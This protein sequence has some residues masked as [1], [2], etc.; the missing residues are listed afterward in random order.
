M[1]PEVDKAPVWKLT[2]VDD[3]GTR[4]VLPLARGE[5]NVGRDADNT[6]RL[7]ERNVSRR[8]M[9]LR[10]SD[11]N[12]WVVEDLNSY[13]GCY[14]NGL[15][16]SGAHPLHHGDLL[17]IGD[18]RLEIADEDQAEVTVTETEGEIECDTLPPAPV[19]KLLDRPDRLVV[20]DG[21]LMGTEY[22]LDGDKVAIGRSDEAGISI[23]DSSVSR[24][25]AEL[26]RIAP[27]TYEIADRESANGIR[28][29]GVKLARRVI[30]E[31]DEIELGD[32]R[33]RFV[34]CGRIYM[35]GQTSRA[36]ALLGA[37][38]VR[39]PPFASKRGLGMMVASG[40]LFGIL[41]AGAFI[42]FR[43]KADTT[44]SAVPSAMAVESRAIVEVKRLASLGDLDGAHKKLVAEASEASPWRDDP[45]IA[46]I[47]GRWADLMLQQAAQEQDIARRRDLLS[48]VSTAKLV[49]AGRRARAADELVKLD[50]K[51]T[52]INALPVAPTEKGEAA[53]ASQGAG[54]P[55]G[56]G[57]MPNGLAA[58]PY[59]GHVPSAPD[60]TM[61]GKTAAA[62]PDKDK[63]PKDKDVKPAAP[64]AEPGG[65]DKARELAAQGG[66]GE[67][68][69]RRLLEP[70]VWSGRATV[71]EIRML[72]AICRHQKDAA[73]VNRANGLLQEALKN[74]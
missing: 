15:R 30:E 74:Q 71:D 6:I 13:N 40:A 5:Y 66:D 38:T 7:T 69:A 32:V 63:P 14:V 51:G 27:G 10:R 60:T 65:N 70:R 73:C 62:G 16:V 34:P 8:H 56:G 41:V 24:I 52:D 64:A 48:Q 55:Q 9:V 37:T 29:N 67:G 19:S 33:L 11:G 47:E 44:A 46:L 50:D 59:G 28:V 49:D 68:K 23:S 54:A 43:P 42:V 4:T 39:P 35:P 17:Q 36:S 53:T 26:T 21:P 1:E 61:P 57:V 58:N 31:G 2:I 12:G 45:E 3:E 72:K 22:A 25:H 18:Y 20:M